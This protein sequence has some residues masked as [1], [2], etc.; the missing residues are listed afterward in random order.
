[1]LLQRIL[2]TL[3][4]DERLMLRSKLTA[5]KRSRALLD[6]IASTKKKFD[7]AILCKEFEIS[8]SNLYRL[9][10]ELSDDCIGI[11]SPPHEFARAEFFGR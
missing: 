4:P 2:E 6:R 5:P 8:E 1:M 3:T 10:S 7:T 11:L 9:C